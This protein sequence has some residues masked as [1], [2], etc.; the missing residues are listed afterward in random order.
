[1]TPEQ[2]ALADG[3]ARLL[4]SEPRI[5]AAW[6]AGSLGKG[7]GD[8]FSDV[9]ILALAVDGAAIEAAKDLSGRL[10]T[11]ATPV[12]ANLLFGGKVINVVTDD[13]ARFDI[14]IIE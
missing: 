12:L 10:D 1:M 3:V 2:Q 14:N 7:E 8:A 13:W 6:L 11:V 4:Q 5:E 9:D